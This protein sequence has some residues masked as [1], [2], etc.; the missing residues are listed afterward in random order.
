MK[1]SKIELESGSMSAAVNKNAGQNTFCYQDS[2]I[3]CD[4]LEYIPP[5]EMTKQN[6]REYMHADSKL[7]DNRK[8]VKV[9]DV[10]AL[11]KV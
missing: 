7:T 11:A 10:V 3:R 2:R 8:Q 4:E 5:G 6:L 1:V 9:N